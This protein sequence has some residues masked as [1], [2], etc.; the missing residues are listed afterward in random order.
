[1]HAS[2]DPTPAQEV[3]ASML[4]KLLEEARLTP[5]I[6]EIDRA[7][8][9]LPI[10]TPGR[11]TGPMLDA[12]PDSPRSSRDEE[13]V[14][15]HLD[16]KSKLL[17]IVQGQPFAPRSHPRANRRLSALACLLSV[18]CRRGVKDLI[19]RGRELHWTIGQPQA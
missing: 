14:H 3:S 6:P 4:G 11:S 13:V 15:L 7:N 18:L 16:L 2:R 10:F 8:R 5:S 17:T 1:M 9:I 12:A 19:A